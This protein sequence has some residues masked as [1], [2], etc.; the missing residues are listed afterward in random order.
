MDKKNKTVL[1]FGSNSF[2]AGFIIKKLLN[3]NYKV[4]GI[5]RSKLIKKRFRSFDIENRNFK[6]Y[7]LDINND[8]NK[9]L[10]LLKKNKPYYI[11]NFASQSMVAESWQNPIHWY[12]TNSHGMINLY[13][14]I[15]KLSFKKK[16]I[17][18]ST[19]EVYGSNLKK[20]PENK[21]YNPSTPYAASRVTADQFLD[22]LHKN[23]NFNFCIIRASNVYGEYQKI[24]RIIPKTI[25][26]ILK[27][28]QLNLHGGG[29]SK[30]NFIHIQ[31]VAEATYK[32]MKKGAAGEIYH[33]SGEKLISIKSLVIKICKLM[34]Y[35]FKDLIK[36]TKERKGKD[37]YYS[38]NN[39][40]IIKQLHWKEKINLDEGLKR[41]ISW[42]KKYIAYFN[43]R[44]ENYW[45]GE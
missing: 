25:F 17:H 19:P 27:R 9:I 37:K 42:V 13:Y 5:S 14:S 40:K 18:I 32:I 2:S 33:V 7:Q 3:K 23:Y 35:N 41:T 16:L 6:F 43:K 39:K 20:I 21:N 31:D 28:G 36:K 22:M 45:H 26:S 8:L 15:F 34:K 12:K 30:R 10:N 29:N 4:I 1:I 38:L 11:I 44:D 24:Y